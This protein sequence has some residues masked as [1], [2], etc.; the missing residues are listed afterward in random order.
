MSD[1][2][3][4]KEKKRI[5]ENP[6]SRYVILYSFIILV[7]T[8]YLLV[9]VWPA[10]TKDLELNATSTIN[11]TKIFNGIN[12]SNNTR[13]ITLPFTDSRFYVGPETLLIFV[14]MLSG[15]LG[16]C[17]YSLW[18]AASHLGKGDFDYEKWKMWYY[19]RPLIGAGLSIF[20]YFLI[21]GGLLTIGAEFMAINIVAIAGLSGLIGM[22]VEQAIKKLNELA[23][24]TFG[25][26]KNDKNQKRE[27]YSANQNS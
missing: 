1:L 13:I 26:S 19:T 5:S 16:A 27:S 12:E 15:A 14:M 20:F 17:V 8:V 7:F 6:K 10:T 25:S 24:A 22:F 21:R 9:G 23:N 4:K 18:A 2:E 3:N 11:S